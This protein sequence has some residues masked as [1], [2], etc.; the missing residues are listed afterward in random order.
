MNLRPRRQIALFFVAVLLPSVLL[1]AFGLR[2]SRQ[3]SELAESRQLEVR[4]RA[5]SALGEQLLVRLERL[6]LRAIEVDVRAGVGGSHG[7]PGGEFETVDPAVVLVAQTNG[8]RLAL[9]WET[10]ERSRAFNR[11]ITGTAFSRAIERAERVEFVDQDYNRAVELNRATLDGGENTTQRAYAR[12]LLARALAKAGSESEAL[13]QYRRLL[14]L[15]ADECDE[16]GVPL[17]FYAVFRL[18]ERDSDHSEALELLREAVRTKRWLSPP[19]LYMSQGL[20]RSLVANAPEAIV[21]ESAETL[22]QAIDNRIR[23]Q[24]LV[25]ALQ[26]DFPIL[27]RTLSRTPSPAIGQEVE[28]ETERSWIPYGDDPWLIGVGSSLVL[29]RSLV[30]IARSSSVLKSLTAEDGSY[31]AVGVPRLLAGENS[32]GDALAARLP[33]L[34][35]T[36]ATSQ[37]GGSESPWSA[38]RTFYLVALLLVI[39]ATLFGGY[40]LW[41]DMRRELHVAQMRSEFV[42]TV[43]HELK[44]PL[45]SIRMFAETLRM[46]RSKDR[47]AQEDYLDTIIDETE[48]L[49]RLLDT[50]LD[51]SKI[52][53]GTRVYHPQLTAPQEIVRAALRTMRDPLQQLGF[54]LDVDVEDEVGDV[55][56]DRDAMKQAILN[57]LSN[58]MKYSGKV[59]EVEVRLRQSDGEIL[60]QVSDHG[61]GMTSREQA[62]IFEEFYRAP[63]STNEQV[64]GTGLGLALV[65][66]FAKAHSGHIEVESTPGQGS[67]FSIHLPLHTPESHDHTAPEVSP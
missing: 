1:V 46:G 43:S 14:S 42:S 16:H 30:V 54:R 27:S 58:A 9:P 5:A 29:D 13:D 39:S 51:F 26:A 4:L 56:V 48:R 33:G 10:D 31:A 45:T 67:T 7:S 61:V 65:K 12:L 21:R 41:R 18:L 23:D 15:G 24:V 19:A 44:T 64:P 63:S 66:H 11:Q 38:R 59:R 3:E 49:T 28:G 25:V 47:R 32:A 20:A 34:R 50:V 55:Y 52:E 37:S 6:M 17:S 60:I 35:V 62:R 53:S 40:L 57:L 2:L 36:F 22:V 8:G